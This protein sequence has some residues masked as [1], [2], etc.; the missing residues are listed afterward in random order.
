MKIQN[1]NSQ[2]GK[3]IKGNLVVARY[4]HKLIKIPIIIAEGRREGPTVLFCA[5]MHG[6]EINSIE[7]ISRFL[8]EFNINKLKGVLIILPIVNPWGFKQRIRYIPFDNL[9]LNRCFGKKGKSVS[10]QIAGT[11]MK[12]IVSKCDFRIYNPHS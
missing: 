9:D 4:N 10:Y 3:I 2:P 7:T 8:H 12:E 6:D 5:G 11:I 1:I